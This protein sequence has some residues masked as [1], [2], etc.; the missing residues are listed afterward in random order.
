M[1]SWFSP[2]TERG[3]APYPAGLFAREAIAAGEI[4]PGEGHVESVEAENRLYRRVRHFLH[5]HT[6]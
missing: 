5:S 2:R 6:R 4:V 3:T 1:S